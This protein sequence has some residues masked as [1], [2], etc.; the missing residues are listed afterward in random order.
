MAATDKKEG[1]KASGTCIVVQNEKISTK[2][3]ES[4]ADNIVRVSNIP[5]LTSHAGLNPRSKSGNESS[6][7]GELSRTE[8]EQMLENPFIE[9]IDYED[10][11]Y[12]TIDGILYSRSPQEVIRC[13]IGRTGHVKIAE[14]TWAIA[15]GAF[16]FCEIE[17]VELPD[18]IVAIGDEA[19]KDC[20]KL[21]HVDFGKGIKDIGKDTLFGGIF[22]GCDS[23]HEVVIPNQVKEIGKRTF[24]CSG[25]EKIT[26]PE[27]LEKIGSM[28]FGY[29]NGLKEIS[30]PESLIKTSMF[31]NIGISHVTKITVPEL[32][33]QLF[34]SDVFVNVNWNTSEKLNKSDI[35]EI[36][37]PD[38][39]LYM[40]KCYFSEDY[41]LKAKN[42]LI[43]KKPWNLRMYCQKRMAGDVAAALRYLYLYEHGRGVNEYLKERVKNDW[44]K[45]I[46][47][48]MEAGRT[49]DVL[50][51]I[52]SDAATHEILKDMLD[53]VDD[54]ALKAYALDEIRQ[55]KDNKTLSL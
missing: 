37:L 12:L 19:F 49:E 41:M 4:P 26:L 10:D 32:T 18:S 46:P 17:S 48:M 11:D 5:I 13:P 8:L 44:K 47:A 42:A 7:A 9:H 21:S 29:C 1:L 35:V 24:Y 40:P 33:G 27:G 52:K 20:K 15:Y 38:D 3:G 22:A 54:A 2:N 43:H 30:L 45:I 39:V 28:A 31:Y 36:H 25:L 50:R 14:G 34:L 16:Q 23:L 55:K 53:E 51:L 6:F